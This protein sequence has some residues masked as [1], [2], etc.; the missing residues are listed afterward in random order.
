M[1]GGMIMYCWRDGHLAIGDDLP[2]GAIELARGGRAALRGVLL[3]A[4]DA[5]RPRGVDRLGGITERMPEADAIDAV[6]G[7]L[8]R[9]KRLAGPVVAFNDTL[10]LRFVG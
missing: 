5:S 1:V 9:L 3:L 10:D 8:H 6:R 2:D 4:R 7:H